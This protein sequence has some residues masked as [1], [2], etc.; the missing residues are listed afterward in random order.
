MKYHKIA[1]LKNTDS[2]WYL[3]SIIQYMISK[4]LLIYEVRTET[5]HPNKE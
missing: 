3:V 1:T 2:I 5:V 4:S